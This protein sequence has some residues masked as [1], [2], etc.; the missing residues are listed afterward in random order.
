MNLKENIEPFTPPCE[1]REDKNILDGSASQKLIDPFY[2]EQGQDSL[3]HNDEAT[4]SQE[5]SSSPPRMM[6]RS[7]NGESTAKA[8]LRDNSSIISI[9]QPSS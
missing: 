9:D 6:P 4:Q 1:L 2:E 8:V 5:E 3:D 7:S